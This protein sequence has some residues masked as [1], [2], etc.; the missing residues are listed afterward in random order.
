MNKFAPIALKRCRRCGDE[1]DAE[2]FFRLNRVLHASSTSRRHPVC[3][4]CELEART[5]ATQH[6]RMVV[7]AR[8]GS[9]GEGGSDNHGGRLSVADAEHQLGLDQQRI[10][11][12]RTVATACARARSPGSSRNLLS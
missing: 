2:V 10:S 3:I 9:G 1:Y 7:K 5:E 6:D 12:W 8:D 11:D 4:G